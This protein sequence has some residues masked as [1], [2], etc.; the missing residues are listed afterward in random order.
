MAAASTLP[1][2]ARHPRENTFMKRQW[3]VEV[4]FVRQ[5]S[6]GYMLEFRYKVLDA[7]KAKPLFERQTKPLLTHAASGAKLIV[8]TPAKTGALRNSN[9]PLVDHDYW[10]FFANPGKLVEPGDL[11]SIE[12]GDFVAANLVVQ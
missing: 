1:A 8:P 11:V 7:E 2:A 6:A 5:T 4:L 9:P 10:M 3:G 12:I